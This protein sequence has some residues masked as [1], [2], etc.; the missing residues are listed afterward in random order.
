MICTN[1]KPRNGLNDTAETLEP[2]LR[3]GFF[4]ASRSIVRTTL[5]L[6]ASIIRS[7][8]VLALDANA[9]TPTGLTLELTFMFSEF[10]IIAIIFMGVLMFPKFFLMKEK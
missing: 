8:G 2:C 5:S 4:F 7:V 1:G 6:D 9:R 3:A 10:L